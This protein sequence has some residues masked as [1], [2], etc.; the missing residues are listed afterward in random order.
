KTLEALRRAEEAIRAD[1]GHVLLATKAADLERAHR[2]G[3]VAILLGVEGAKLLEGQLE[4]L[5]TFHD[6]GLR[7]LQLRWAV[8]NQVVETST[9][10]DFGRRVVRECNRLGI[11]ISLTHC[12]TPAFFEVAEMS[13][14][15]LI[16]CHSVANRTPAADGDSLSDRQL[17]AIARSRGV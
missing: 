2:E 11:L 6:R 15:P 9:L 4:V 10:T 14:K 1:P 7:E 16:V 5:K 8:P 13:D 12:P 3:K 17:R